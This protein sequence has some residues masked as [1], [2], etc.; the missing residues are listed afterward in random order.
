MQ[1]GADVGPIPQGTWTIIGPPNNTR[2]H[3]PYVLR[4]QPTP[5]TDTF[6]RS[7]FLVHGDSIESPGCASKGCVIL[8]RAIREKVWN[9]GD[10]DLEVL[11]EFQIEDRVK[12][13][14][15]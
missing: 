8:P 1:A 10:R 15:A 2:Y 4:W 13:A 5:G 6:G 14:M 3:G 12:G 11:A 7:G 9:S